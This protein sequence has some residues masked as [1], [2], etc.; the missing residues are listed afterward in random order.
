MIR[1]C[2]TLCFFKT[3]QVTVTLANIFAQDLQW[4]INMSL[5]W[6]MWNITLTFYLNTVNYGRKNV[7]LFRGNVGCFGVCCRKTFVMWTIKRVLP[8]S[9]NLWLPFFALIT[10]ILCRALTALQKTASLVSIIRLCILSNVLPRLIFFLPEKNMN[11][12]YEDG[13]RFE[14]QFLGFLHPKINII[15]LRWTVDLRCSCGLYSR[16]I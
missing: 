7:C 2:G 1:S 14:F 5:L 15:G 11:H 13:L 6:N 4:F 16:N 10:H 3:S 12:F 8:D 9:E